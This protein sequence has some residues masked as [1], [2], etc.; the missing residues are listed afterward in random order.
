MVTGWSESACLYLAQSNKGQGRDQL[1][2]QLA[3]A[4]FDWPTDYA[5]ST[6]AVS[7]VWS[8]TASLICWLSAA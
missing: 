4:P 5:L 3:K 7:S 6:H 2:V 8:S 1:M